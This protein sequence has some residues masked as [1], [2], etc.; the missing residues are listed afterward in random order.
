MWHNYVFCTA[1]S[2]AYLSCLQ[3]NLCMFT[4]AVFCSACQDIS[5]VLNLNV[6]SDCI[7]ILPLETA[8]EVFWL[9]KAI[10]VRHTA[11]Q[12]FIEE[13]AGVQQPAAGVR[14]HYRHLHNNHIKPME[15]IPTASSRSHV[16]CCC[17]FFLRDV[18]LLGCKRAFGALPPPTGLV[19]DFMCDIRYIISH[20]YY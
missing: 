7:K 10:T 14:T 20:N 4:T 19:W 12:T 8:F 6:G 16:C 11:L 1:F 3:I 2:V 5:V 15:I 18:R 9:I 13:R 17:F